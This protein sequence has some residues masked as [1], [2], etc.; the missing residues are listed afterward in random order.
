MDEVPGIL[1]A[2][3]SI[4]MVH[5]RFYLESRVKVGISRVRVEGREGLDADSEETVH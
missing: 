4:N 2:Y 1:Q 5:R 3:K